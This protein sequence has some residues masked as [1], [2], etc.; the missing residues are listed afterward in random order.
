MQQRRARERERVCRVLVQ[1]AQQ[2][3]RQVAA[4]GVSRYHDLRSRDRESVQ[5][6]GVAGERV[7]QLRGEGGVCAPGGEAVFGRE[8]IGC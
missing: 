4:G 6:V 1:I 2:A 7:L 8:E 5:Q 3:E